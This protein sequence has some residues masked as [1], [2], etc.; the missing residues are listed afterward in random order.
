MSEKDK[1]VTLEEFKT[2]QKSENS[3]PSQ[4]SPQADEDAGVA[5]LRA[6]IEKNKAK[7][8]RIAAER[9]S[10]IKSAKNK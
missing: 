9:A 8:D 2:R 4:S 10:K 6:N 7:A 3:A 5:E 1:V